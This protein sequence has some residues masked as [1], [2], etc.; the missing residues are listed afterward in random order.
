MTWW[1]KILGKESS[2]NKLQ[3]VT[4]ET[5]LNQLIEHYDTRTYFRDKNDIRKVSDLFDD[6]K[7]DNLKSEYFEKVCF[8]LRDKILQAQPD[9]LSKQTGND[10]AEVLDSIAV[11]IMHNEAAQTAAPELAGWAVLYLN[12][13]D[14]GSV[15]PPDV[16]KVGGR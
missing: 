15:E 12:A 1:W 5:N 7:I 11:C 13:E 16:L 8:K 14:K 3:N 6:D 10:P 2:G 4:L 9:I